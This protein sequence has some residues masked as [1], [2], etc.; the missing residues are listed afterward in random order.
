MTDY[1]GKNGI[2]K[3]YEKYLKGIDGR[4]EVEV[5]SAGNI[6]KYL[7]VKDPVPGERPGA[8]HRCRTSEKIERY[9]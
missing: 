9:S 5:D 8:R 3:S 2:E 6:K 1:V 4:Q 7:G